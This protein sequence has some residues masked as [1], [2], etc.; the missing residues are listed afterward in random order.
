VIIFCKA[1][2]QAPLRNEFHPGIQDRRTPSPSWG[3]Q[4]KASH[5]ASGEMYFLS[6]R[7]QKRREKADL[8]HCEIVYYLV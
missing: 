5:S 1:T 6:I 2:V 7:P 3:I 8:H 4:A